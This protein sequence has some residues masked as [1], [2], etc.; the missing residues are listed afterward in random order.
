[1]SLATRIDDLV[2]VFSPQRQTK[3]I[4][5]R[6]ANTRLKRAEKY[7]AASSQNANSDWVPATGSDVNTI[8]GNS[9]PTVRNRTYQL[10]RDMPVISG[11]VNSFVDF[12]VGQ[13]FQFQ[14]RVVDGNGR[15]DTA[16]RRV[17]ED[18]VKR[19]GD[20]RTACFDR[21]Q[22]RQDLE[23]LAI[24]QKLSAGEFLF[25][26][27]RRDHART[28]IPYCLNPI[29]PARLS[30]GIDTSLQPQAGNIIRQGIEHDPF[31]GEA[32]AYYI[33][34]PEG[35]A[36]AKVARIPADFVRHGFRIERPGQLRGITL[37]APAILMAH[38]LGDMVQSELEAADMTSKWL[39][40]ITSPDPGLAQQL[41]ATW[42]ADKQQ[43]LEEVENCVIEY[44][45]TGEDI[46]LPTIT[47]PNALLPPFAK[48]CFQMIAGALGIPY[49]I[50]SNDYAGLNYTVLRGRRNDF[51][52]VLKPHWFHHVTTFL[53]PWLADVI[54]TAVLSGRIRLKNYWTDPMHYRAAAWIPPGMESIDPLREVKARIEEI[55]MGLR[56]PQEIIMASG[57]DPEEI[58][59][60]LVEWKELLDANHLT[61]GDVL[62]AAGSSLS[63]SPSAVIAGA[64]SWHG[65][66]VERLEEL[67]DEAGINTNDIRLLCSELDGQP[68]EESIHVA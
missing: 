9:Q 3:R 15:P 64:K 39:A 19:A 44:L 65:E 62:G 43:K 12:V 37:L 61:W 33:A 50:V 7:A 34:N 21:K 63:T 41:R 48:F 16:A 67:M 42:D 14:S 49:E 4:I 6:A 47:R 2:G 28:Y 59:L 58:V 40:F 38:Y 8:I 51:L 35:M 57:R 60:Q 45:R 66:P 31:S 24:R 32:I 55:M 10:I 13:G 18:A 27:E 30:G 23:R 1:M 25:T 26:V 11:S 46:K 17:I 20:P 52:H 22:C 36:A 5:A 54:D 68:A 56:S 53:D 29:E